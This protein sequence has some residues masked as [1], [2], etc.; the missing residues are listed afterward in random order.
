MIPME[1]IAPFSFDDVEI[2]LDSYDMETIAPFSFDEDIHDNIG[3]NECNA[4]GRSGRDAIK[5]EKKSSTGQ[6]QEDREII[7]TSWSSKNKPESRE[8]ILR[9]PPKKKPGGEEVDVVDT[10]TTTSWTSSWKTSKTVP[11]KFSAASS[12][13]EGPVQTVCNN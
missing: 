6:E 1:M 3:T 2:E 9:R 10:T 5:E 12:T 13:S 7:K 11:A 8:Y 4:I